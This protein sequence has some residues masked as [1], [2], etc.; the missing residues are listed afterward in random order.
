MKGKFTMKEFTTKDYFGK[1]VNVEVTEAVYQVF[2]DYRKLKERERYE[3]RKHID[4]HCLDD[5]YVS[6]KLVTETLEETYIKYEDYTKVMEIVENCTPI[7][8]ERFYLYFVKGYTYQEI[9]N[10]QKC[11]ITAIMLSIKTVLKKIHKKF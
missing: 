5:Y 11:S 6:S 9:A 8:K 4:S 1:K 7:Q 10:I 3:K 2:E